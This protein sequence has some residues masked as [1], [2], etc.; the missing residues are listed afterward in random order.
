MERGRFEGFRRKTKIMGT[1]LDMLALLAMALVL[2]AVG[3][4]QCTVP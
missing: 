1:G 4:P 2:D 3:S